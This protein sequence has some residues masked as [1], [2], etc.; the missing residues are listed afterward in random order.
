MRAPAPPGTWSR[1]ATTFHAVQGRHRCTA[2]I[3]QARQAIER[4][5]QIDP[6]QSW[7]RIAAMHHKFVGASNRDDENLRDRDAILPLLQKG[8]CRLVMHGHRHAMLSSK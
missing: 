6:D 8:R 5:D 7:L 3:H 4:C 1:R 2:H